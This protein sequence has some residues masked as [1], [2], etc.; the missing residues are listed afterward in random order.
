[1]FMNEAILWI[2]FGTQFSFLA[3]LAPIYVLYN[4]SLS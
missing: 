3:Y 4:Y 1:M 2:F